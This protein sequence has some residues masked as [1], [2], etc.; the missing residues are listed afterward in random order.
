MIDHLPSQEVLLLKAHWWNRWQTFGASVKFP[1]YT[2]Q[3]GFLCFTDASIPLSY[4]PIGTA[5]DIE[6][7]FAVILDAMRCTR[8]DEFLNSMKR[9]CIPTVRLSI[10]ARSPREKLGKIWRV[11][12]IKCTNAFIYIQHGQTYHLLQIILSTHRCTYPELCNQL[13]KHLHH[14]RHLDLSDMHSS[15]QQLRP[16]HI[17][18]T[19][20]L[21]FVHPEGEIHI[22]SP[23][24]AVA[25]S[26][27]YYILCLSSLPVSWHSDSYQR[28]T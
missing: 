18:P 4:I 26:G 25:C 27:S 19:R 13:S 22:I 28:E 24:S 2:Q 23:G 3:G 21:G 8:N 9:S 17:L 6:I 11:L 10:A 12:A 14:L 7:H 16:I 1:G 20:L 15:M 5:S